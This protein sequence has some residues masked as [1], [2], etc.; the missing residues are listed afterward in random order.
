MPSALLVTHAVPPSI[1][2]AYGS[3]PVFTSVP[4]VFDSGSIGLTPPSSVSTTHGVPSSASAIPAGVAPTGIS[5]STS[6]DCASTRVTVSEALLVTHTASSSSAIESGSAPT[7]IGLPDFSPDT[8]SIWVTTP[9]VGPVTQIVPP[10]AARPSGLPGTEIAT[11]SGAFDCRFAS[12]PVEDALGSE[13]DVVPAAAG[14]QHHDGDDRDERRGHGRDHAHRELAPL[15]DGR[16]G[17]GRLPERCGRVR[18]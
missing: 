7:V 17:G 9:A 8:A 14:G 2:I 15:P 6:P 5:A 12:S 3:R 11:P 18:T 4:G 16:R 10:P 1:R 13:L